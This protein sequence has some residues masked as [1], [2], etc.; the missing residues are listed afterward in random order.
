MSQLTPHIYNILSVHYDS[1]H[2]NLLLCLS[3]LLIPTEMM[4]DAIDDVMDNEE[5]I[6]ESEQV[7]DQIL[8]EIGISVNEGL[9]DVPGKRTE[10]AATATHAKDKDTVEIADRLNNLGKE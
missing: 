4:G 3:F 1:T 9:V 10:V 5:D 8:D 7:V 2:L 6:A